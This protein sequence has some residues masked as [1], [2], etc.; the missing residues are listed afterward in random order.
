MVS[1]QSVILYTAVYGGYETPK[2]VP[3]VDYPCLF[4]TDNERTAKAAEAQGWDV[5]HVNHGITT[6]N[7]GEIGIVAPMLAHK[8]WK[9]RPDLALPPTEFSIWMDG[10]MEIAV[11]G[12]VERCLEALG[13]DDLSFMPHPERRCVFTEA[14]YS[15]ALVWRYSAEALTRQATS[16]R[17]FHPDNLGL[18]A[19]GN[20]VRRHTPQVISLGKDWWTECLNWSHQDQISIPVLLRLYEQK[21]VRWN[22]RMPWLGW[23]RLHA[24]G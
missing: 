18:V 1:P 21:G 11:E 5:R 2:P 23:V 19:T 13:E 22:M 3:K 14:S 15:A 24:H 12:Y 20:I 17:A 10:S 16:Y 4:Y 8:W 6:I 9:C 7:K